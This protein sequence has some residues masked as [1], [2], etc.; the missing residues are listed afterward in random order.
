[1][2]ALLIVLPAWAAFPGG[3]GTQGNPYIV[4]TA[5]EL[6]AVRDYW[7]AHFKLGNDIN[8]APYLAIGGAGY[9]IWGTAG[10]LPISGDT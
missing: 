10:W 2:P 3:D 8:L 9:A 4:T 6:N 1:L 5:A 7:W